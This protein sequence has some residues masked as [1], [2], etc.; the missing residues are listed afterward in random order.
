M[1][2]DHSNKEHDGHVRC[3]AGVLGLCGIPARMPDGPLLRDPDTLKAIAT[4][5]V[6]RVYRHGSGA[7]DRDEDS[8]T[9]RT[10]SL[11]AQRTVL[12]DQFR[13]RYASRPASPTLYRTSLACGTRSPS[14]ASVRRSF[15]G[16]GRLLPPWSAD[17]R[18]SSHG[19]LHGADTSLG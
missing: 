15:P 12:G 4:E 3:L 13:Q 7:A 2:I 6:K 19:F 18:R 14:S 8:S 1:M 10:R 5:A 9:D 17:C 16:S 11:K